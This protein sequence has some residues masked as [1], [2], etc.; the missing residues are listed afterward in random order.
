MIQLLRLCPLP[1]IYLTYHMQFVPMDLI[2]GKFPIID[3]YRD[4]GKLCWIP[5]MYRIYI[6][7]I[8]IGSM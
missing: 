5:M 2:I 4:N 8:I 1:A 3:L 7:P 6:E